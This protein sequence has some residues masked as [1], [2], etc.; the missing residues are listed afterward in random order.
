MNVFMEI[1]PYN[2]E[3]VYGDP[4]IMMNM[5]MEIQPLNDE[6]VYG[7]PNIY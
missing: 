3:C 2:D 6:C 5:F 7:D 1:Q 4:T